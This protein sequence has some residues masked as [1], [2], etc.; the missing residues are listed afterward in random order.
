MAWSVSS[1]ISGSNRSTTVRDDIKF[2][3][4][5]MEETLKYFY[6]PPCIFING[7]SGAK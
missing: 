5:F 7:L 3:L 6:V 2:L 1:V 4:G